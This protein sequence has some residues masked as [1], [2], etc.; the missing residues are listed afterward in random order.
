MDL[1]S[2]KQMR[3]VAQAHVSCDAKDSL[4]SELDVKIEELEVK[5]FGRILLTELEAK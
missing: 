3:D 4:L 1:Q 2:L 5:E